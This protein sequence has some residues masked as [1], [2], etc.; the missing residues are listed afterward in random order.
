MAKALGLDDLHTYVVEHSTPPDE[1]LERLTARTV[2]AAGV[3]ARMQIAP[4]QGAFM[5][6]LTR[7]IG[8]G[9]VLEIGTF[10]GYS[11]ICIA[12][13]LSAEGRLVCL[14]ISDEWT[15][16]GREAWREAGVDDRIDL[17]IGPAAESLAAMPEQE[18]FDMAFID[19]DKAGYETYLDLVFPRLRPNGVVLVDNVLRNGRVLDRSA[20]DDDTVAIRA[21]NDARVGDPRWDLAM[22]PIS[23]GLTLLRKR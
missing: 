6:W 4:E 7:L 15:S 16:I 2:E 19:A 22:L 17:R 20:T 8:A 3:F 14:D 5:T 12:R 11:A 23:D 10:T 1:I 13:G 9:Q 21:F 18:Q